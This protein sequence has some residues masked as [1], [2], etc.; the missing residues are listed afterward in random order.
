[1][2]RTLL[3]IGSPREDSLMFNTLRMKITLGFLPVLAILIALGL[4]AIVMFYGLGGN[5]DVILR[6]NYRSVL[7]VE[8]M[9][10]A[11]DRMDSGLMFAASGRNQL[12]REQFDKYRNEFEHQFAI[13]QSNATVPGER[14]LV[15]ELSAAYR[16][17]RAHT[18]DYFKRPLT[19]PG[20]RSDEYFSRLLPEFE[21]LRRIEDKIL[22]LN[23]QNMERMNERALRNAA[24]S[25]RL[26]IA[27]LLIAVVLAIGSARI[28]T[29]LIREPIVALTQAARAVSQGN[30]DQV[31][32]ATTN[33]DEVGELGQAFNTMARTIREY[34]EAGSLRL[35]RA[36]KT[37]Q[38]TID[39]FPDPVV[40][41]DPQ[42]EVERVNPAASRLLQATAGTDGQP[43]PW[44]PPTALKPHLES[45]LAGQGDYLPLSLD[46]AIFLRDGNQDKYFMPRVLRIRSDSGE[47]LGAAV[48]LSDVTKF[49]LVDQLKSDMISTVSHELKTP[50]TSLQMVVHLLLEEVV[51]PLTAKQTELLV[52]ARQ[53]SDRLLGMINDLLDLTRIEQGRVALDQEAVDAAEILRDAVD[54]NRSAAEDAAITLECQIE[55]DLS[56]VLIDKERI[57]HVFDNLVN[58]ALRHTDRG[59][60][61]TLKA[62]AVYGS[63]QYSITDSGEGI[64]PQF[65]PRVFDKF[66][67]VPGSKRPGGAGLGLAIVR[68]IV[69][70]HGGSIEA[71]SEL[72]K[73]TTFTFNLPAATEAGLGE[74]A[75]DLATASSTNEQERR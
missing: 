32:P 36:Q 33:N 49:R 60:K 4:W 66:Y 6:E 18:D 31:V 34:R 20:N 64:P 17:Y 50:L 24:S 59:G 48:V 15:D 1:M 28:L 12:A 39:S 26:M 22:L 19:G 10:E 23:Q 38:A 41:V 67:R 43:L 53:D 13:E 27:A 2:A 47:I 30:L 51:G 46:Q 40:V 5:I 58:N 42:G 21:K 55:P 3:K 14:E 7:A 11:L 25:T 29:R 63:V 45:V 35:L 65:L 72:G 44:A 73:G 52:A 69:V 61:I 37:A 62:A 74:T 8:R 16:T 71:T 56:A 9:K 54:R 70:A 57:E 75:G 68:E